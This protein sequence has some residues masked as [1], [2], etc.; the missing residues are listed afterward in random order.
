MTV[1][2]AN[3]FLYAYNA[4][5]PQQPVAA[6]WLTD[7]LKSGEIIGS[8]WITAW[9]FVRIATNPRIWQNPLG[10]TQAFAILDQWWTQPDVIALQ[11]GRRHRQILESLIVEDSAIGPLVTDAAL[12]ALAVENG[13]VLTSTDQDFSRFRSLRWLNPVVDSLKA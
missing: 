9:A 1:L 3:V 4:G 6:K 7:L 11:P 13:A 10:A 12:A 8:P 2:D 5:A